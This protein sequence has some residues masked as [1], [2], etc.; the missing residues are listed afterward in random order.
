MTPRPSSSPAQLLRDHVLRY[1]PRGPSDP[2]SGR[3]VH[4][5]AASEEALMMASLARRSLA[6][7]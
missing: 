2:G 4:V 6:P 1:R 5:W 7:R 3:R